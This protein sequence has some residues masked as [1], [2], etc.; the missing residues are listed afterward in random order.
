MPVA[1][2]QK[3]R[4]NCVSICLENL[5]CEFRLGSFNATSIHLSE[6]LP[7]ALLLFFSIHFCVLNFQAGTV[8]QKEGTMSKSLE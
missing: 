4:N 7:F 5:W 6:E 1:N 3:Q 2:K 8:N